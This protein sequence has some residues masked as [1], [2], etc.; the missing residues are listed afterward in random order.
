MKLS[1]P[2]CS[3]LTYTARLKDRTYTARL[4]DRTYTAR[5]QDRCRNLWQRLVEQ[6]LSGHQHIGSTTY[7]NLPSILQ[8][9]ISNLIFPLAKCLRDLRN[10]FLG[11]IHV[12]I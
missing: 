8:H 9:K 7:R 6:I 3:P 11:Q 2:I 4:K 10:L 5:L 12:H 1:I